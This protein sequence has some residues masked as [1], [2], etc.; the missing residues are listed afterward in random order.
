MPEDPRKRLVEA[1]YDRM[2]EKYLASKEP[3]D[4]MTIAA[5]EE[6]ASRLPKS[7][8]V[9]DLGCGAGLPAA[10]WLA[11][12]YSTV[13]VDI[14]GRQI[15]LAK[16]N[17][18]NARFIKS[19]MASLGFEPGIFDAVVAFVSIIHVPREEHAGVFER[20]HGWLKNGGYFLATLSVGEWEGEEGDWE[21]WGAAMWWSHHDGEE[22]LKML[23]DAGFA[24]VSAE[25]KSGK[26]T[27]DE[28]EMWLWVLARKLEQG[29]KHE[30]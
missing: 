2:A 17:A 30:R 5:L 13:G 10:R 29:A 16:N 27:G 1:G 15:E 7:A 28:K 25:A 6:L 23:R 4:P 26:G 12:R 3:D 18:P 20:I 24:V 8:S 22:N 11:E 9:L 14:S 21:G 19:D